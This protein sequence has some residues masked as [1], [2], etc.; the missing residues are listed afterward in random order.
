MSDA[1]RRRAPAK[2]THPTRTA[3][4]LMAGVALA[5]VI[6]AVVSTFGSR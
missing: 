1:A 6:L 3:Y 4:L 5:V 2:P